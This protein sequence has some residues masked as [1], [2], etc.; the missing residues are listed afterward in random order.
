MEIQPLGSRDSYKSA[1][2]HRLWTSK[3]TCE[4]LPRPVAL[5][6]LCEEKPFCRLCSSTRRSTTAC[7]TSGCFYLLPRWPV[8]DC[9]ACSEIYNVMRS[10]TKTIA[11]TGHVALDNLLCL[12]SRCPQRKRTPSARRHHGELS[13]SFNMDRSTTEQPLRFV[14]PI[15]L[16]SPI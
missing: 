9:C 10:N 1:P 11:S 15:H 3:H 2:N 13:I 16:E 8:V 6:L 14:V 7:F 4:D 5:V 12:R